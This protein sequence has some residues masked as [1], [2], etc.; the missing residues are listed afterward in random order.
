MLGCGKFRVEN[1]EFWVKGSG[2][3]VGF[4]GLG[5]LGPKTCIWNLRIV[6]VPFGILYSRAYWDVVG[7]DTGYADVMIELPLACG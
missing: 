3:G 2:F 7:C 5:C 4:G 6:C 1:L